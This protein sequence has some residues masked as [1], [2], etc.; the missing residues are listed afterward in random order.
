MWGAAASATQTEGASSEDNKA[1]N[2][3]DYWYEIEPELFHE[4]VGPMDTSDFYHQYKKDIER[5]KAIHLNSFR[6]SISWSRLLP[7]GVHTNQEAVDFYNEVFDELLQ[8]NI[9]P[10]VNLFHFD[11]PLHMQNKG[12][13]ESLEVVEA[14]NYYKIG[15]AHV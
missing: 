13:W 5:M 12:G 2:I 8:H 11:M 4:G 3:W 6:T 1:K 15:R 14:F 10:I 7:D 9:E